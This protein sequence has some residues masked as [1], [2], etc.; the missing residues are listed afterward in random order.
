MRFPNK[1]QV[2]QVRETYPKGTRVELVSMSDPYTTLK[3]GDLGTVDAVDDAG[4]VFV[5]WDN[6]STL[7]AVYGVDAIKRAPAV[8]GKVR[9]QIL[10]VGKTGKTNMFDT[11]AVQRIAF[12]MGFYELVDFIETDRKAYATFILTGKAP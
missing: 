8:G 6:G 12:D 3:P 11:N 7:A 4:S 5:N 1:A 9:E 10:A 2:E